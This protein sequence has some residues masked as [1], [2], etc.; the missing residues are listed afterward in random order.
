MPKQLDEIALDSTRGKPKIEIIFG[1]AHVGNYRFF[2][3]DSSGKNPNELSHGNN[4]DDT[5]DSFDIE[6]QPAA[7]DRRILSFELILQAAETREGQVYSVTITVRQQG[8]VCTGGVI[9]ESG[10]LEDVKS[11]IGF[12]RFKTI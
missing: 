7:L 5:L 10:T 1:Q 8:T 6:E 2:L 9:S 11:L 3:W 12:R 4:V